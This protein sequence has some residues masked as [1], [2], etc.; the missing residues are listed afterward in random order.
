MN[1]VFLIIGMMT[2][3]LL[4]AISEASMW[5]VSLL[6][7]ES[8]EI[9]FVLQNTASKHWN[10]FNGHEIITLKKITQTDKKLILEFPL[11]ENRLEFDLQGGKLLQGSWIKKTISEDQIFSLKVQGEVHNSER[12]P[13][14]E[15]QKNM[16]TMGKKYE[17]QFSNSEENFVGLGQ[18]ESGPSLADK[19]GLRGTKLSGSIL[20]TTGDFRF[21]EGYFHTNHE[22]VMVGFDGQFAFYLKATV[23]KDG[24][25]M[26]GKFYGGKTWQLNFVGKKND[27]YEL[28][29]AYEQTYLKKNQTQF[30][31]KSKDLSGKEIDLGLKKRATKIT[32][33]QVFGSWCPN[34]VDETKFLSKWQ[35]TKIGKKVQ[36]ISLAF[37]KQAS[38]EAALVHL[39]KWQ[40][41]IH[42]NNSLVL[43]SFNLNEKKVTDILPEIEKHVSFP[44]LY[45]L[46]KSGKIIK[47]HTG[48]SGPATGHA[49]L[50]FQDE[51]NSFIAQ[52]L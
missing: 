8:V 32:M 35:Q 40:K 9:P 46:D 45:F 25:E 42:I 50:K 17:I 49:Y 4:P 13:Y 41:Q 18:F 28:P 36:I 33:V 5:K 19:N 6:L 48:F 38:Q 47:I 27:Q 37:E 14:A 20:T 12:F 15:G 11:Y 31:F 26:K 24:Q 21:L 34:C 23:L 16:I 30:H 29:N 7:Q 39:K 51:L 1:Q 2:M 22:L 44:T 52:A 10:L 3:L 43:A